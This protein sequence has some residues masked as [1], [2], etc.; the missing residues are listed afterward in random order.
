MNS[1]LM[2]VDGQP[3][4]RDLELEAL[5]AVSGII[6]RSGSL[7]AIVRNEEGWPAEFISANV[8]RLYG[9]KPL[10]VLSPDFRYA[11]V[12][13]PTDLPTVREGV[14][15]AL[16]K[17]AVR[18][19]ALPAYRLIA[20]NGAVKWVR[21]QTHIRRDKSARPTHLEVVLEDVSSLMQADERLRRTLDSLRKGLDATVQ[22]IATMGELRD[23]YTSGHQKN[24]ARLSKSIAVEMRL[25]ERQCEGIGVMGHLHDIGKIVVPAEILSKPG[26]LSDLEFQIIKQHPQAGYDILKTLEFP[27]PVAQAVLQ[28]HERLDGTGYPHGVRGEKII[29]EAR[30]LAVADV[31]EAI[32]SHRPYRPGLGIEEALREIKRKR[33]E[34]FDA[35]VVDACMAAIGRGE[36]KV[37]TPR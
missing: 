36:L 28:H 22:A 21:H 1:L 31:V 16:A 34:A 5:R 20:K 27:W 29:L 32:T 33:D 19:F 23:P 37:S 13:H 12:I 6:D 26:K 15:Q 8:E 18:D 2:A 7:A 30:I 11:D 14:R 25:P 4:E 3:E 17:P 35:G 10:E 24:V 9:Y